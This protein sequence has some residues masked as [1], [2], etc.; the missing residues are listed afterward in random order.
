MLR[1]WMQSELGDDQPFLTIFKKFLTQ[2]ILMYMHSARLGQ[3]LE[4][5]F[6]VRLK[7]ESEQHKF[8][9]EMSAV[10]GIE[11]VSLIMGEE[12]DTI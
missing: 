8:I 11:R 6:N 5:S 4:V 7:D 3:F 2:H 1:F 10:E 9:G 12:S